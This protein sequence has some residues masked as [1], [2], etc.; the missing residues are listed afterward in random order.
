MLLDYSLKRIAS[1]QQLKQAKYDHHEYNKSELKP[2][3]PIDVFL[4]VFQ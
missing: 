4:F 1:Q 3:S 2:S